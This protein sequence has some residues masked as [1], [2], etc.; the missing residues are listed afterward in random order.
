[1]RIRVLIPIL[2]FVLL[3]VRSLLLQ[4]F[5]WGWGMFGHHTAYML[6]V[7]WV[8]NGVKTPVGTTEFANGK[9]LK[10]L[11]TNEVLRTNYGIGAVKSWVGYYG[12]HLHRKMKK[13]GHDSLEI[14]IEFQIN[15]EPRKMQKF[16]IHRDDPVDFISGLD[17]KQAMMRGL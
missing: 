14:E 8:N 6:Q 16:T 9:V 1:M 17:T 12:A 2:F 7:H 10:R 15:N 3:G 4:D 5:R 11:R 13:A